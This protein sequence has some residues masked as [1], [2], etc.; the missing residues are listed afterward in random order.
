MNEAWSAKAIR[1]SWGIAADTGVY[2]AWKG[3]SNA[4]TLR[5]RRAELEPIL[6]AVVAAVDATAAGV[7]SPG[8]RIISVIPTMTDRTVVLVGD[9]KRAVVA[10]KLAESGP[11]IAGLDREA[12]NLRLLHG[13]PRFSMWNR[14]AP[15][16]LGRGQVGRHHFTAESAIEGR[17]LQE[18]AMS[19]YGCDALRD[20]IRTIRSLHSATAT[21]REVD[22]RLIERWVDRPILELGNALR[23]GNH[24]SGWRAHA[25]EEVLRERIRNCLVARQLEVGFIHGDFFP[26]NILVGPSY[27]VLGVVDWEQAQAEYPVR[28]DLLTLLLTVRMQQQRRPLGSVIVKAMQAGQL[29][30]DE[31][32]WLGDERVDKDLNEGLVLLAWLHLVSGAATKS[33]RVLSNIVWLTLDIDAVLAFTHV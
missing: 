16:L 29:T 30:S 14:R 33:S 27:R 24:Y 22:D 12:H 3:M 11:A 5:R 4:S 18:F 31:Q 19:R 21:F 17:G 28:L 1:L 25:L 15:E 26:N 9:D 13:D 6:P 20:A 32:L 10:L 7:L 2:R 8:W 23:R